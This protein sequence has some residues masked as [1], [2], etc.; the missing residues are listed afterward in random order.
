LFR[1]AAAIRS[2]LRRHEEYCFSPAG[3]QCKTGSA[4]FTFAGG[5][6]MRTA[7]TSTAAGRLVRQGNPIGCGVRQKYFLQPMR[8]IASTVKFRT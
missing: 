5:I 7:Q 8:Q 2:P 1:V 6:Q 4:A 3:A